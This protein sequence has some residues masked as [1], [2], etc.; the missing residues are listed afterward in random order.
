[1]LRHFLRPLSIALLLVPI[2]TRGGEAQDRNRVATLPP[3]PLSG[4]E[5]GP[6]AA[7]DKSTSSSQNGGA[8]SETGGATRAETQKA[9][10]VSDH[11]DN[12]D[13]NSQNLT[14]QI[15]GSQISTSPIS[16]SSK[17]SKWTW[18]LIIRNRT[19]W[20]TNPPHRLQMSRTY[21]EARGSYRIDDTWSLTIEGRAH[22]DPV[23]RLGF[24]QR[25]L[26]HQWWFDPRQA[27][28]DGR[29]GRVDLR[30]GLQQVVWGEADG[31]RVLDVINPLDYREFI[32]EDFLDSRRPLWMARADIP[33]GS[34][35]LQLL[36]IPYFAPG[37]APVTGNEFG[38]DLTPVG[39]AQVGLPVQ[40]DS[41]RR[42]GYRLGSS[43]AGAR[44]RRTVGNWD[45]T[46]NYF[47][48]WEDLPTSYGGLV[49][50][51]PDEP[52][53]LRFTPR[54]DR[55]EVF[56][57]TAANS[58]GRFVLRLEG[59][60]NRRKS[61]PVALPGL[62]GEFV[63]T[64]QFSGVAGLDYSVSPW[65]WV[66]GQYFLQSAISPPV[67][68]GQPRH[69]H[70]ASIYLRTNFFRET[71]RPELFILTGLREK[72]YLLRPR[73]TRTFG[74]HWSLGVGLDL[75]GG[76]RRSLFGY[77]GQRDRLVIELKWMR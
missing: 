19:G 68:L 73:L 1:M 35:S 28:V 55:K 14:S 17:L 69:N 33:A 32:L 10:E 45:L 65:L 42:P 25:W 67:P 74:D 70:L 13:S 71:L 31:L 11:P 77:F 22:F 34:G 53:Q 76:D 7:P 30:L 12:Q 62:P 41:V 61:L 5:R 56:G 38:P 4:P 48:G 60:I 50:S 47:L 6:E 59:G 26:P 64:P 36:W 27:V 39:P 40:F 75:L 46:A 54:F 51:R 23:G 66:S 2:L 21:L 24:P 72:Q 37:R 49:S 52:P 20:R 44:Y 9:R 57:G 16:S 15:S 18:G 58:F 63:T 8:A 3:Q 29:V 43:Q